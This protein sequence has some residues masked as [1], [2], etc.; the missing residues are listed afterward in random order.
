M[1]RGVENRSGLENVGCA[2][3]LGIEKGVTDRNSNG[4]VLSIISLLREANG[5]VMVKKLPIDGEEHAETSSGRLK[6][7]GSWSTKTVT[8]CSW[9]R[10]VRD[11]DTEAIS[12]ISSQQPEQID[13]NA[14]VKRVLGI[15]ISSIDR[16]TDFRDLC[17][18]APSERGISNILS[19]LLKFSKASLEILGNSGKVLVQIIVH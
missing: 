14:S 6:G 16:P 9:I 15:V 17:E 8:Y 13:S 3:T 5:K 2:L 7:C 18:R 4:R 19:I 11:W 12:I 1:L 10:Q